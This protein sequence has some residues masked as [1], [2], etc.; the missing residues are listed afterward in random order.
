MSVFLCNDSF[1]G[2]KHAVCNLLRH[3]PSFRSKVQSSTLFLDT[4]QR[5]VVI[6]YQ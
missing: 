6:P 5:M 1:A 4:T 3:I 2:G